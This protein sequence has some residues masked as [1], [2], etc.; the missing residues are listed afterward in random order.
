MPSIVLATLCLNEMQWLEKL[1]TQHR[2]WK[3]LVKWVFVESAD[4]VYAEC[5]PDMVSANGLSVD[6]TTEY[7]ESL[8]S[9]DKDIIH[10]K[11][12]FCGGASKD[13]GKCEARSRYLEVCEDIKPDYVVVLDSDEFYTYASQSLINNY[14]ASTPI[15]KKRPS[16]RLR[17]RHIWYPPS[18]QEDSKWADAAGLSLFTHEV[19][20]GYWKVPHTRIW[21]WEPGMRYKRNHNWPEDIHGKFLTEKPNTMTIDRVATKGPVPQCV[22]MGFAA[23]VKSREAKHKYY[24]ERGEGKEQN[25]TIRARRQGYVDNR[26]DWLMW[27]PGDTLRNGARVVPYSGFIPE[28]FLKEKMENQSC[29]QDTSTVVL[30]LS[31]TRSAARKTQGQ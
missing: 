19:I 22:H 12:G 5:S 10:I 14:L 3:G 21:G 11:H 8:C 29:P 13:Q 18:L 9:R 30:S 26:Q 7:L 25:Y 2:E 17:Q 6:G 15:K 4:R 28:C 24:Q 1:Y 27:K 20:G 31:S 23:S 16:V